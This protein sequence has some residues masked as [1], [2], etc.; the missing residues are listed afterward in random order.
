MFSKKKIVIEYTVEK[1]IDCKLILK[2]KFISGDVLFAKSSK[3]TS[4]DAMM[5]IENIF[6]ETLE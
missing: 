4:C 5:R 3:C 1:C 2:R 6:A